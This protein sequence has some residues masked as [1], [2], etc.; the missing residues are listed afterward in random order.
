MEISVTQWLYHR[1]WTHQAKFKSLTRLFA[2][3]FG[4]GRDPSLLPSTRYGKIEERNGPFS[5]VCEHPDHLEEKL[6]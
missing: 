4:K 6:N 3:D 1:K 2:F 5:S